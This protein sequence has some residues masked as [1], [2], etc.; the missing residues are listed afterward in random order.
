MTSVELS[1][2]EIRRRINQAFSELR[3]DPTHVE[4]TR[5]AALLSERF[6]LQPGEE[7]NELDLNLTAATVCAIVLNQRH[8]K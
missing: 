5:A 6:I 1:A 4:V 2:P 7:W 8:T 3:H